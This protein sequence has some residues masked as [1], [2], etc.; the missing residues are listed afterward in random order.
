MA[1]WR[2]LFP[3]SFGPLITSQSTKNPAVPSVA[4]VW[5]AMGQTVDHDPLAQMLPDDR[6]TVLPLQVL[7]EHVPD[8]HDRAA[9]AGPQTTHF[10]DLGL[11]A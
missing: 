5:P 11:A 9:R 8:H 6:R 3:A 2:V 7:V 10:A 1:P 4:A